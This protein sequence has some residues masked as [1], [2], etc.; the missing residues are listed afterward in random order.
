MVPRRRMSALDIDTPLNEVVG[1]RGVQPVLAAAGLPRV[2]RQR[3]RR[4]AHQGPGRSGSWTAARSPRWRALIR[5]ISAVHESVTADR[6]LRHYR[7]RRVAPGA[8]RGRVRR[9]RRRHHARGRAVRARWR[10]GRRVQGRSAGRGAA[11][12][13]AHPPARAPWRCTTPRRRSKRAWETDATT[14][15]GLVTAALGDLP[16]PGDKAT[17]GRFEFQVERVADRALESVLAPRVA[18]EDGDAR[19]SVFLIPLAIITLLILANALF[20]AAEFAIVGASRAQHRARRRRRAA[21]WPQRVARILAVA[22]AA[23]PLHRHDADRHLDR[24]PGPGDVRRERAGRMDRAAADAA[25]TQYRWFAAHAVA[26]VVAVAI[27]TYFHIV[28]GEMVPKA[29]ALQAAQRTV[30]Y[31]SPIITAMQVAISPLVIGAERGR[32]R[33]AVAARRDA[34][35]QRGRAVSHHRGAA[36]HH[37]RRARKAGC[38]AASRAASCGELFEFGNLTAGEVMVPRVRLVGIPSGTDVD[39]LRQIIRSNPHTRY[40]IYN[41]DLDHIVGSVHIKVLLRHLV[42]N[43]PVTS[44]DARPLPYVPDHDAARRAAGRDAAQPGAHGGGDGR[45]RRHGRHRDHRGPVRGSGGRHHG[46]ARPRAGVPRRRRPAARARHRAA[47]R[48]RATRSA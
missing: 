40:P 14:V 6:V 7:E 1:H 48:R 46:R 35:G 2:A 26:S 15:G 10:G 37:P 45:A 16:E 18:P 31:V 3:R 39:E 23:G 42:A 44:R 29:L 22:A 19:M 33:P 4:A 9:H 34:A 11:A 47:L 8:G 21:G 17:I 25:T 20:V 32:Q 5:P 12:G 43:R 38:C 41:G 28:L 27:L 36:A 30:L 24:Q 13:R